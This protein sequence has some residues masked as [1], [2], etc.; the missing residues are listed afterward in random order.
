MLPDPLDLVFTA[1]INQKVFTTEWIKASG[2]S[3]SF[4]SP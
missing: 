4:N 3:I 1:Q 2:I